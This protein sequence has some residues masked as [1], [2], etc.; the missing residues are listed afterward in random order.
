MALDLLLVYPNNRA[1]AYG[2]LAAEIAAVTPP[3]GLGLIAAYVRKQGF[4][5]Q[6]L[7]ADA[8]NFTAEQVADE[9][10]RRKPLLML[11]ATDQLNSG[12]VTK[13]AAASDCMTALRKRNSGI[14][15]VMEGVSPSAY[16][17]RML[18][19]ENADFAI[20]GEAYLPL[21]ELLTELKAGKRL[22]SKPI[23]GIWVREGSKIVE[24]RR[25]PLWKVPDE[26]PMTPWDLLPMDKYRA[27]HWHCFDR[28]DRR[29][30]YA[31]IWTNLGCPYDCSFC[32]VNIVFGRP[33][34]RARTAENVVEEIDL[35]VKKYRIS[36]LR[37]VD[38]IFT[39][40]PD[41]VEKLC[42]LIIARGCDLN[43]WAYARVE[44]VKDANLV[45]KM[46]KAG[47]RWL[48][49]GIEAGDSTVRQAVSKGSTQNVIDRAIELTKQADINIVGNF[50]FGLPEDTHE[51]MQATLDM[52]KRYNFEYANFYFAMAYPGTE[53]HDLARKEG[54][55]LP[56]T[57][58]GYGQY[59]E[60]ALPM[61]TKHL[62]AADIVRFRDRAFVEYN[63]SP[64]YRKMMEKK[65]GPESVAYIDK[66]L[67][68]K[69]RRKIL[70]T[71]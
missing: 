12:D 34:Y 35:L 67:S 51:T 4:S 8:E 30:P 56:D 71:A 6:L 26:L 16:P 2:S 36:N 58:A 40:Q 1:R 13:M 55:A 22:P 70:E 32:S 3:V 17:E 38:N 59:S 15:T 49:Y 24:S 45:K 52:A 23:E 18:R 61:A 60:D 43:I 64:A 46:R 20:Q 14:L 28:L 57:W 44:T 7:D 10:V 21:V 47:V 54:I 68:H 19:E 33:N 25:P 48:A 41:L 66:I 31:A 69:I 63:Q 50:I 39:V 9:V 42:D 11:M 53:L 37:I 65:F 29:Q 27:H 5:V 62:S